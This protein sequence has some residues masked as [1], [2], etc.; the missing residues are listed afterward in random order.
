MCETGQQQLRLRFERLAAEISRQVDSGQLRRLKTQW[1]GQVA[2]HELQAARDAG[3]LLVILLEAGRVSLTSLG[4]IKDQLESL[5]LHSLVQL[6]REYERQ[7]GDFLGGM[8]VQELRS[9]TV[10]T[11][12]SAR[13]PEPE[14]GWAGGAGRSAPEESD[15][16]EFC[17]TQLPPRGRD[18]APPG[19]GT[20]PGSGGVCLWEAGALQA[21]DRLKPFS[22]QEVQAISRLLGDPPRPPGPESGAVSVRELLS[23]TGGPAALRQLCRA[24]KTLNRDDVISA[25][26]SQRN[27]LPALGPRRKEQLVRDLPF[28]VWH[29]FTVALSVEQEDGRDWRLLAEK[30]GI[31]AAYRE[32]WK[33]KSKIPAEEVLNSWKSKISEATLD[34]LFDH[35]IAMGREDLADML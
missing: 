14:S 30:V 19:H 4:S 29:S 17:S 7:A 11:F 28:S 15:E 20:P 34:K 31:S 23:A 18:A 12:C 35:M 9:H 22:A 13:R 8:R 32:L 5:S 1:S 2:G 10:E 26:H 33:Q 16:T 27:L 6:C 3:Q 25:M 24:L 21:F